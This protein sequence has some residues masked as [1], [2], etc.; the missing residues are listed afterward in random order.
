[1]QMITIFTPTYNRASTLPRLYN[2]LLEQTNKNFIWII[3]DDGSTDGTKELVSSYVKKALI[4]IKY[5]Y[6][7]N[8]GKMNAHNLGVSLTNTPLFVC[9]DSDD[10][11]GTNA[12]KDILQEYETIKDDEKIAGIIAY[13]KVLNPIHT[14]TEFPKNLL[15]SSG[16]QLY[17][18]G[19]VGETTMIFKSHV[20]KLYPFPK[21]KDEKF[22]LE[23]Y[24][25]N[26]IDKKYKYKL[27]RKYLTIGE[28]QNDGYSKNYWKYKME[29][30]LGYALYY[31]QEAQ[32][33]RNI[34]K[35]I[36]NYVR[37]FAYKKIGNN[38]IKFRF[39]FKLLLSFPFVIL[40]KNIYLKKEL[41]Q[42]NLFKTGTDVFH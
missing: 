3:V 41:K 23:A 32:L 4:K 28:Y 34:K 42:Y 14:C 24:T 13:R 11:L 17:K 6:I 25:Y 19:Y 18:K 8:S 33:E 35:I 20:I 31:E 39:C 16:R 22:I 12:I 37:A 40:F 15:I 1:M 30:P 7:N 26:E 27:L 38:G 21:I 2:S 9:V 36:A 5:V 29:N 10:F